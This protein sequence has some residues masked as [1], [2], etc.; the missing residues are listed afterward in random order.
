MIRSGFDYAHVNRGTGFAAYL[1]LQLLSF[2]DVDTVLTPFNVYIHCLLGPYNDKLRK[3]EVDCHAF[4]RESAD[5]P[6]LDSA[7][8][9]PRVPSVI[10]FAQ[11]A[12]LRTT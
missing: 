1:D 9:F 11:F 7:A 10:E 12:N 6:M 2:F 8:H 3:L 4:T 5:G